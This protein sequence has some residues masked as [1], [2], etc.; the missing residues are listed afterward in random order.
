MD[1]DSSRVLQREMK[2][3]RIALCL[4]RTVADLTDLGER[5]SLS[6]IPASAE[7][8]DGGS[9]PKPETVEAD[10]VLVCVGRAPL[11]GAGPDGIR[12][13]EGGWIRVNEHLETSVP[14]VFA[15]GDALGPGR[16]M[17][18]HLATAEGRLAAEN[19]L[20]NRRAMQ[21]DV[22][23]GAI[24]TLPEVAGVGLTEQEACRM[25]LQVRADTVLFRSLAKPL[26]IGRIA[27]QAKIVSDSG[28]GR[29]LGVHLV[30]AHATDLIAEAC[31]ALRQG[32]TVEDLAET[33]HA[34]PTLAEVMQ[35]TALKALDR[36]LHG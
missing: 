16:P 6:L 27:G 9:P 3:R 5:L 2:K 33:I 8:A 31:L 19:A 29:I 22:V 21:Y 35:E 4:G 13:A 15:I 11:A 17:L 24:Y 23:P 30:G 28:S 1:S 12:M 7:R 20:G 26:V 32:C 25:G 36:P 14:G 34:H 10:R 18:A